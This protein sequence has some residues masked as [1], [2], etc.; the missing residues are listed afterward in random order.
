V[1]WRFVKHKLLFA[2]AI[3]GEG[4]VCWGGS[5]SG[6]TLAILMS[7]EGF[8]FIFMNPKFIKKNL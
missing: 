4:N 3:A 6:R 7:F 8:Y 5:I 1:K 2:Y